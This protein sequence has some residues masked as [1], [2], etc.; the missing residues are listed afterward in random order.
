MSDFFVL[1]IFVPVLEFIVTVFDIVLTLT[2][3]RHDVWLFCT[4][5]FVPVLEFIVTVFNIVLTL[6]VQWQSQ[7]CHTPARCACCISPRRL[8]SHTHSGSLWSA[9]VRWWPLSGKWCQRQSAV[10]LGPDHWNSLCPTLHFEPTS[11][12]SEGAIHVWYTV[13]YVAWTTATRH[14]TSSEQMVKCLSAFRLSKRW[15]WVQ[16][17]A[18]YRRT[19]STSRLVWSEGQQSFEIVLCNWTTLMRRIRVLLT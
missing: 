14:C 9:V 3:Q 15:W 10:Y 12:S 2:V 13:C 8:V 11:G 4:G 5:I 6:T 19:Y 18:A 17:I 7:R 16:M 1:G